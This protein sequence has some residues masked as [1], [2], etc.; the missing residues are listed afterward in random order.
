FTRAAA[1]FSRPSQCTTGSGTCSPETGKFSTAFVVSLPQSCSLS[2]SWTLAMVLS[3]SV[4]LLILV[5]EGSRQPLSAGAVP[6]RGVE[7]AHGPG[8][9]RPATRVLGSLAEPQPGA[10]KATRARGAT[11]R[12]PLILE[13]GDVCSARKGWRRTRN[14]VGSRGRD[15]LDRGHRDVEDGH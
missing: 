14:G 2:V 5:P 15:R 11:R 8:P 10:A 3:G 7:A 1:A 4:S 12:T 13:L 9:P 6:G